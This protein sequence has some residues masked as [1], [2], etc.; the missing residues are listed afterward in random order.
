M[1]QPK[2]KN[3][4]TSLEVGRDLRLKEPSSKALDLPP[5]HLVQEEVI[6]SLFLLHPLTLVL[7]AKVW[8]PHMGTVITLQYIRN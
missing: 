7:G 1:S 5:S 8:V 3:P 2:A 6:S 4:L